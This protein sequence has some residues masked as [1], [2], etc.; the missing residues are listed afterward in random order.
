MNKENVILLDTE[1]Y[2]YIDKCKIGNTEVYLL[3]NLKGECKTF[4][5]KEVK[6]R[7]EIMPKFLRSIF[8]LNFALVFECSNETQKEFLTDAILYKRLKG[9]VLEMNNSWIIGLDPLFVISNNELSPKTI[10]I[11]RKIQAIK[12][13]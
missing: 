8:D 3:D 6:D 7:I 10:N 12:T 13:K 5:V 4:I 1:F 11:L 9:T 2:R